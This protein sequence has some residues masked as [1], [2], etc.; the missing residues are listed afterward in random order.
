MP[1]LQVACYTP[2]T[3]GMIV[4]T[5]TERVLEARRAVLEFLLVNH[6]L[7]CPVCDQAGECWLQNF[8]MEHGLYDSR[9]I[10]DKVKKHKAL[11]I[12]P[13]VML[14]S[15]RC[16]L[17]SRCVRFCDEITET[18]ELGIFNRGDHAELLPYP[19]IE[20]DNNY[21]GNTIDICPVGALTDK[22]FRF[23]TRVWYLTET[24]SIC[25]G[26]SRGCNITVHHNDKRTYKAGG[27]RISRLKPRYNP[28]VNEWWMCDF[29]RYGFTHVDDASRLQVPLKNSPS[30][31][32]QITWEDAVNQVSRS[33][34]EIVEKHG[35]GSVGVIFSPQMTNEDLFA[36]RKLFRDKLGFSVID[37]VVQPTESGFEDEFLIK[38]DKNPNT[39]GAAKLKLSASDNGGKT[40]AD[41]LEM[42]RKKE[43]K[44]L[45]ICNHDL[46][47]AFSH[48]D[49][50]S[51][52]QNL[53]LVVF[54][55]TNENSTARLAHYCLPS[56]T[57]V[58][59]DGT[60]TNFGNRVQ[61]IVKAVEPLGECRNDWSIFR[62]IGKTLGKSM[63]YFEAKDIFESL[64][65]E[66]ESFK[67]LTFEQV[68]DQG[69]SLD[70]QLQEQEVDA[71]VEAQVA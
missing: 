5:N 54:Q 57:F 21:A 67:G 68:G 6:P 66:E 40:V 42:A 55:G 56:A 35:A 12:G 20:L 27:I 33:L 15:E 30:G 50:R 2:V 59:K 3:D 52:F 48:D 39:R 47:I 4:H 10:E 49:V 34:F 17:C 51:A 58:E 23:R 69:I 63:P 31:F 36:G 19:G 38:A 14:D 13:N 29:G 43:L 71:S 70:D 62:A 26:C 8:Y 24:P 7:D 61:M 41:M 18:S 32:E 65:E 37:F 28:D 45:Y 25:P 16:I 64:A 22:D 11:R 44:A 9:M 1:K 53:E 60:F 46:E